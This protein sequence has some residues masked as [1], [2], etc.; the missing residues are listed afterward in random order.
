MSST[1]LNIDNLALTLL[2]AFTI[3]QTRFIYALSYSIHK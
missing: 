2:L 1:Y 3:Q